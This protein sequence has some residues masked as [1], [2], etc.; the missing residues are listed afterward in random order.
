MA[1]LK[2]RSKLNNFFWRF[3][4]SNLLLLFIPFSAILITYHS[5]AEIIEEEIRT[6]NEN[7]LFHFFT[8]MDSLLEDVISLSLSLSKTD[9]IRSYSLHSSEDMR[10]PTI[11]TY[12]VRQSLSALHT[13]YYD[14]IFVVYP[15]LDKIIGLKNSLSPELFYDAYYKDKMSYADFQEIIYSPQKN[16]RPTI[17]TMGEEP[18]SALLGVSCSF[19]LT[20]NTLSSPDFTIVIVLNKEHV[21]QL[22]HHAGIHNESILTV[23]DGNGHLAISSHPLPVENVPAHNLTKDVLLDPALS[24]NFEVQNFTS[25]VLQADYLSAIPKAV[26]W[27]RL[28][29]LRTFSLVCIFLCILLSFVVSWSLAYFNHSPITAIMDLI[30]EKTSNLYTRQTNELAYINDILNDAFKEISLLST[31]KRTQIDIVR[32]KFLLNALIG[33]ANI[34][35]TNENDDI[36]QSNHITLLSDKFGIILYS[37]DLEKESSLGNWDDKKNIQTLHF[38]FQNVFQE[39]CGNRHR[40]YVVSISEKN[41]ACIINFSEN[42]EVKDCVADMITL[43]SQCKDFLQS[44]FQLQMCCALSDVHNGIDGIHSCYNETVS[45][46]KYQYLYKK[47][48]AI[49]Y[50]QIKDRQF[51]YT[52]ANNTKI[53]NLLIHFVKDSAISQNAA[54]MI[55]KIIQ[56]AGLGTDSSLESFHCFQYESLITFHMLVNELNAGNLDIENE[57]DFALLHAS[58]F[59]DVKIFLVNTLDKLRLFY[60]ESQ[61]TC[62]LCD[63]VAQYLKENFADPNLSNKILGDIFQ[64]SPSYLSRLFKEQKG[65]SLSDYLNQLRLTHAKFLLETTSLNMED[66]ATGSGYLSSSTLIK[67]FKKSEG[68]T[69]GAYRNTKNQPLS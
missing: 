34:V 68:I 18:T 37:V 56:L 54:D 20:E 19:S 21:R 47:N 10:T 9:S 28:N 5:A 50:S 61:K 14:N 11:D 27:N 38:I 1:I 63:Q 35:L 36:F 69:P 17:I 44:G 42:M 16:V 55:T 29:D 12:Y 23:F 39:L 25:E 41:Y 67:T 6:S 15:K 65:I 32:D 43:A 51:Q 26:F 52:S 33:N 57:L 24:Y 53:K 30:K 13:E 45:A 49:L 2:F 62:T 22:F 64:I 58:S 66:V 60:Q 46:I 4:A 31:Q 7:T 8:S 40:G 48:T 59:E 3:M